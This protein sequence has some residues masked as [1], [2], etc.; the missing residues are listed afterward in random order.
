MPHPNYP[1]GLCLEG[2]KKIDHCCLL[3]FTILKDYIDGMACEVAPLDTYYVIF[4][5]SYLYYWHGDFIDI[6]VDV[7]TQK[8]CGLFVEK[9]TMYAIARHLTI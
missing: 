1:F 3:K 4:G 8:K 6:I 5:S 9:I 2:I 7:G